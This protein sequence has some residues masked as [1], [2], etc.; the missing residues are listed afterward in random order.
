MATLSD[1]YSPPPE[2]KDRS[3]MQPSRRFKFQV[4]RVIL[5]ILLFVLVYCTLLAAGVFMLVLFWR[6]LLYF[7]DQNSSLLVIVI[8]VAGVLISVMSLLFMIRFVFSQDNEQKPGMTEIKEQD[9]PLLFSFIRQVVSEVRTDFPKKIFLTPDVNAGVFYG[10]WFWSLFF[11]VKKNLSIG[12]GLLTCLN[13]TEFKG[14]LAHEFGHF[15]QG[16]IRLGSYVYTVNRALNNL[17]FHYGIWEMTL[18]KWKT[19][20][21]PVAVFAHFAEWITNGIRR[22]LLLPYGLINKAYLALSREMEY[23]ADLVA[24]SVAGT[25]SSISALRRTDY[26]TAVWQ[27]LLAHLSEI[28]RSKKKAEN[29]YPLFGQEMA[30]LAR[31]YEVKLEHDLP[32]LSD[33][34]ISKIY[35]PSRLRIGDEWDSHPDRSLREE[36]FKRHYIEG[37]VIHMPATVL[38]RN[39]E[40]VQVVE[41]GM[42]YNTVPEAANW[43]LLTDQEELFRLQAQIVAQYISPPVFNQYYKETG[44]PEMDFRTV[45]EKADQPDLSQLTP[46]EL[47][48]TEAI[49]EIPRLSEAQS[50]LE[51]LR[52]IRK[53]RLKVRT[54]FWEGQ[55]YRAKEVSKVIRPLEK[56]IAELEPRVKQFHERVLQYNY[57]RAMARN[58][59]D[60]EELLRMYEHLQEMQKKGKELGQI[61]N[62]LD[63]QVQQASS[64]SSWPEEEWSQF[65]SRFRKLRTDFIKMIRQPE[66]AEFHKMKKDEEFETYWKSFDKTRSKELIVGGNLDQDLLKQMMEAMPGVVHF[67]GLYLLGLLQ[68]ILVFQVELYGE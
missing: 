40:Q 15:S 4:F 20:V 60:G 13:L 17:L 59:R 3:F 22:V 26:A 51:F 7:Q 38:L 41:T 34:E 44:L 27:E 66:L 46:A 32:V 64:R 50:S 65:L 58:P 29:F 62:E 24:V 48:L 54:F 11:P 10:N 23:H 68:E 9:Q 18:E 5:A 49:A 19:L 53:G 47:Y 25:D 63:Y 6:L 33:E 30:Q 42:I 8:S 31:R 36:N 16:S 39:L 57:Q 55:K 56:E 61:A 37:P 12:L 52:E 43:V 21:F 2:I 28:S 67:F 35:R 1:Y 14:V 45:A